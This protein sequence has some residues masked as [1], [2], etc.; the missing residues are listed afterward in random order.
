MKN[1]PTP[2]LALGTFALAL[3]IAGCTQKDRTDVGTKAKEVYADSKAA[4]A[5][6]WSNLKS[7]TYEKREEFAAKARSLSSDMDVK[8]AE[9]H[10]KYSDEKASAARKAAMAELRSAE[11]DY[12]EKLTALSHATAATWDSAK[13]N[14]IL[15]WERLQ[16]AYRKAVAE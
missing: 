4:V 2:L 11:A 15:A 6:A 5:D 8:L 14:V 13:Q 16:A 12:K 10:A 3:V 7:Y 9:I 1:R